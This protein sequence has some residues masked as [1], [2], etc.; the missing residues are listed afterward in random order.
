MRT[1]L[2]TAWDLA[3]KTDGTIYKNPNPE[4]IEPSLDDSEKVLVVLKCLKKWGKLGGGEVCTAVLTDK[5]I[6]IFS[7][8]MMK[9]VN[10]THETVPFHTITGIDLKRKLSFG[11]IIEFSRA[12]NV[13]ALLKCDETGAH[14]FVD[15][16]KKLM[17]EGASNQSNNNA[18]HQPINPIDQIKKLAE[19]LEAGI[20]SQS[21]F[22]EKKKSLIDRI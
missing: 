7:R 18:S 16:L 22:D 6:H 15:T 12:A 21:E 4:E 19:L 1:D 11:W 17:S 9:S 20:I 13:D 10:R 14:Q 5:T 3:K 2:Q 8:G